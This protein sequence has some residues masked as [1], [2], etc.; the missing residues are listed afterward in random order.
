[1]AR[2]QHRPIAHLAAEAGISREFLAK[3]ITRWRIGGDTALQDAPCRPGRCPT[4]T[5]E[6][7]VSA[8]LGYRRRKWSA[9]RIAY[10]LTAQG[11]LVPVGTVT[12]I[13]TR[14]GVNRL[15]DLDVD[16]GP[17]RAPGWITAAYRGHVVH[18]DITKLG[19]IPDGG[20][21]RA[22]SSTARSGRHP[23]SWTP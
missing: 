16:G 1:M 17:L 5:P 13:L 3:W 9:A 22:P 6:H 15:W 12:R 10:E 8:V 14:Y 18:V 11:R 2:C 7:V 20:G 23:P 21:W 4:A 19:R